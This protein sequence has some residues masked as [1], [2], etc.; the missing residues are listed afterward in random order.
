MQDAPPIPAQAGRFQRAKCEQTDNVMVY[1][2]VIQMLEQSG[3]P[4]DVHAHE[5]VTSID[6]AHQKVP[7][8]T[9][10]LL[11]TVVFRIKDGDWILAAVTGHHRIHYKKLADA[12]QVNRK[13]LR[14]IAPEQVEPELGFEIGGVGPFPVR[15]DIR[16]VFDESLLPLGK[17]FCGSGRNTRTI[18]MQIGDLIVLAGG[19]VYPIVNDAG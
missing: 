15:G 7:H 18:E 16:V 5:P 11:K 12:M 4:F 9:H 19:V 13:V 6:E 2:S 3:F 14:S 17:V 1:Q 10:N 8:L